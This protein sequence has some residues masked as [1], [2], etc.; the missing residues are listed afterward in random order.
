M[1]GDDALVFQNGEPSFP[2]I[3]KSFNFPEHFIVEFK[4]DISNPTD[5][6]IYNSH[7]VVL[8]Q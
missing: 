3:E 4:T 8:L 1:H 6:P 2:E 5:I 7:H